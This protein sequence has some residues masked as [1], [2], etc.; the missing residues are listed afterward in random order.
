MKD[1]HGVVLP[2]PPFDRSVYVSLCLHPHDF[3]AAP[4][5]CG[6]HPG[7]GYSHSSGDSW[8]SFLSPVEL[9][10]H[11]GVEDQGARAVEGERVTET[12]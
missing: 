11:E 3:P 12:E 8:D 2:L 1:P 4:W 10:R 5:W 7:P 9:S 6:F